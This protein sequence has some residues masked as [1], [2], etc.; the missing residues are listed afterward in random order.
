MRNIFK[1]KL[2]DH[3]RLF[4]SLVLVYVACRI[5]SVRKT[6]GTRVVQGQRTITEN[7]QLVSYILKTNRLLIEA[8]PSLTLRLNNISNVFDID[9]EKLCEST[10]VLVLTPDVTTPRDSYS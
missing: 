10:N 8:S 7:P 9:T 5:F 2:Q 6:I 1:I 4:V 3:E